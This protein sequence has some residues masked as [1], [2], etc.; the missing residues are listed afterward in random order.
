MFSG[1]Y[2]GEND[3]ELVD[4]A[5]QNYLL[6]KSDPEK[7]FL[8]SKSIAEEAR[9]KKVQEAELWALITQCA[10]FKTKIDFENLMITSNLMFEKARDL[11]TPKYQA[12]AKYYL[13]ESY[14]FNGL[15]DK[16]I[17]HLDEGMLYLQQAEE[18]EK[19]SLSSMRTNFY[20]AYSNFYLKIEDYENQLKYISLSGQEIE[21]MPEGKR[22]QD[23]LYLNTSNIAQVYYEMNQLDSAEHYAYLSIEKGHDSDNYDV[24]F[25]NY[26]L[27][28][29]IAL[30]SGEYQKALSFFNKAE[31][32][33]GSINH[34]NLQSLYEG[35]IELFRKLNEKEALGIYQSK[36]DS[37]R[38]SISD[39]QNKFL[40]TLLDIIDKNT[41]PK[42]FLPLLFLI[43]VLVIYAVTVFRKNKV[44]MA[45]ELASK[46]YLQNTPTS[47]DDHNKLIE[48]LKENNP[49]YMAYFNEIY[50]G[51]ANSLLEINPKITPADIEFCSLLIL[52]I[53][54]KEIA[55]YK[56]IAPKTVRNKKHIIRKKLNIPNDTDIYFWFEN[57]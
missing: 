40:H 24:R 35:F 19:E 16:A 26:L 8:E 22:K 12:I 32:V 3:K 49:S 21:K 18:K 30:K 27:L 51:F 55:Q 25:M 13:F 36:Q 4:R 46:E 38:L 1:L 39:N 56:F 2:A 14:L 6:L 45:Q 29:Q 42:Y 43:V 44:L 23:F 34:V 15:N 33:D 11:K 28:G 41:K 9:N 5:N 10:Y 17:S 53:P 31:Q 7:A 37:L 20:I 50:P 57:L 47:G 52:K 54:T 48:L